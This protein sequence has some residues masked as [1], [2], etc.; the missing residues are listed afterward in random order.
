MIELKA[1]KTNGSAIMA[2]TIFWCAQYFPLD[3][4]S[5]RLYQY[6]T[7]ISSRFLK[8]IRTR[9]D[10]SKTCT[11]LHTKC[12]QKNNQLRLRFIVVLIANTSLIWFA[13]A[14]L[15]CMGCKYEFDK[16]CEW[17]NFYSKDRSL[18]FLSKIVIQTNVHKWRFHMLLY[19][20]IRH[21]VL[22]R[23]NAFHQNF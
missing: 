7:S 16:N 20:F 14:S 9:Q 8:R 6:S 22:F 11:S 21:T 15:I 4:G 2:T 17:G 1:Q 13:N 12:I 5:G 19:Q 3:K 18:F 23:Q 10:L